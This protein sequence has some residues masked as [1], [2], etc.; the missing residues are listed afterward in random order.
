MKPRGRPRVGRLVTLVLFGVV[1]GVV[2]TG[3]HRA[4]MPWGVVIALAAVLTASVLARAHAGFPGLVAFGA[5]WA[6][7]V[8][9]LRRVGPGGDVLVPAQPVG[10]VWIFGGMAVVAVSAFAPARWFREQPD[11]QG[12]VVSFDNVPQVGTVTEKRML[13]G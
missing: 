9:I 2:G 6:T 11:D 4:F 3:G 1:T 8:E 13:N 10:Y 5:G 7:T 12:K